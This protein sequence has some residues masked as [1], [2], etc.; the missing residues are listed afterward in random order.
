MKELS[1][2]ILQLKDISL[3][4][5]DQFALKNLNLAFERGKIH[6]VLGLNGAGKSMLVSLIAGVRQPSSGLILYNGVPVHFKTPINAMRAGIGVLFQEDTWVDDMSVEENILMYEYALQKH[7]LRLRNLKKQRAA[8]QEVLDYFNIS[9]SPTQSMHHVSFGTKQMLKLARLRY[10][11]SHYRLLVL[12]EPCNGASFQDRQTFYRFIEECKQQGFTIIFTTHHVESALK[13]CDTVTLLENSHVLLQRDTSDLSYSDVLGKLS[14]GALSHTS[15]PTIAPQQR[16][17]V[18][19]VSDACTK[20]ISQVSFKLH[21]GEILGIAGLLGSGRT[22]IARAIAGLDPLTAGCITFHQCAAT[23]SGQHAVQKQVAFMPSNHIATLEAE[24]PVLPNI[25]M[26]NLNDIS[27]RGL[28][29][30]KKEFHVCFPYIWKFRIREP[31]KNAKINCLSA[32]NQRKTLL[33]RTLF[34]NCSIMVLDDPTENIDILSKNEIY[35]QLNTFAMEGNSIIFI[36]SDID[37]LR[38]LCSRVLITK[39]CTVVK[40][41]PAADLTYEDL[42]D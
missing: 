40:D 9:L 33:A 3:L 12:D 30:W 14:H 1:D 36:S 34:R 7:P 5:N 27:N 13:H 39:N 38:H 22:G 28:L 16:R 29:D 24:F 19:T 6:A 21:K 11:S 17:V 32:G 26:S 20:R 4:C 8:C 15:Y 10:S 2:Y 41:I 37:E 18:M 35:N 25:T 42:L 23:R 31:H